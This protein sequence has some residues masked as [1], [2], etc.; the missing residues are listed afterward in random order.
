MNNFL[1]QFLFI[2]H[3]SISHKQ[4]SFRYPRELLMQQIN[5]F[6]PLETQSSNSLGGGCC[7]FLLNSNL[8][9]DYF[10]LLLYNQCIFVLISSVCLKYYRNR[11]RFL[12]F[13]YPQWPYCSLI[14]SLTSRNQ[15]PT[16]IAASIIMD[17]TQKEMRH[18][19][20]SV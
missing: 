3:L 7:L 1:C 13:S 6:L 9:T 14:S 20:C 15:T 11:H 19:F 10:F 16:H 8:D 5:I 12:P 2:S 4:A 18:I 17:S